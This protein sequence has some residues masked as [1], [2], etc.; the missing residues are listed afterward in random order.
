MDKEKSI[1]LEEGGDCMLVFAI[2]SL[3]SYVNEYSDS[4]SEL[5]KKKE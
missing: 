5:D 2:L 1:A 3:I 4:H